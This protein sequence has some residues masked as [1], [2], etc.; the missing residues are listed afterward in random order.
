ML[1]LFK[2]ALRGRAAAR[3]YCDKLELC[4]IFSAILLKNNMKIDQLENIQIHFQ[5]HIFY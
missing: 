2:F 1:K 5:K 3:I 4:K